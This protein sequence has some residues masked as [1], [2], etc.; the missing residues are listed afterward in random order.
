MH[1]EKSFFTHSQFNLNQDII[2]K[3]KSNKS[4]QFAL[5]AYKNKIEEENTDRVKQIDLSDFVK[6]T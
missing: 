2:K 4:S 1:Q 3:Q 6:Q 5:I